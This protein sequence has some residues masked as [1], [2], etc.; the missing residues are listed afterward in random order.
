MPEARKSASPSG[1][2]PLNPKTT[3]F[4]WG[5]P[6]GAF[7]MVTTIPMTILIL[8]ALCT[9]DNCSLTFGSFADIYPATMA[10][11]EVSWPQVW[12]ATQIYLAWIAFHSVLYLAPI[13]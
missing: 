9:K 2:P 5:G 4:E 12:L 3:D 6:L 8:N 13:G 11:I 7:F 10:A 1:K